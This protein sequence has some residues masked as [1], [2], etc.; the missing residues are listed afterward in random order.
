[1]RKLALLGSTGSIGTCT[2]EVV[3]SLKDKFQV[4]GLSANKNVRRLLEQIEKFHPRVVV[5]GDESQY[6]LVKEQ[7]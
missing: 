2:L 5:I 3:E 6:S 1:M 7:F 4:Y